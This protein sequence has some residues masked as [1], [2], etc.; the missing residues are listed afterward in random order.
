MKNILYEE[1]CRHYKI[2]G[3]SSNLKQTYRLISQFF[4]FIANKYPSIVNLE[5]LN[6]DHS[7]SYYNHLKNK[8][9]CGE[10]SKSYLKD[11]LYAANKLFKKIGKPELVY[12]VTAIL[13][14]F[15]GKKKITVTLEE[16][17][18]I[19]EWRKKYSKVMPPE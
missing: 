8:C 2:T 5:M 7:N 15:E 4:D 10:I 16:F 17:N 1:F 11:T 13:A 18:N 19:K 9:W 12:D 6:N 3:A 14:S